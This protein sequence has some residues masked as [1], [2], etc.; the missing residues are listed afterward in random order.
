M[1]LSFLVCRQQ[2][3]MQSALKQQGASEKGHQDGECSSECKLCA[4]EN[5]IEDAADLKSLGCTG[6]ED[7]LQEG[8]PSA[9]Q[10]LLDAG[11]KVWMLTGDTVSTAVNIAM[12][13]NL[14]D[15]DMENDKRLFVFDKDMD[16]S[17]KIRQAIDDANKQIQ[18]AKTKQTKHKHH[19]SDGAVD[20]PLFGLAMHGD[21]WKKMQRS[22]KRKKDADDK[23]EGKEGGKEG[24]EGEEKAK[25]SPDLFRQKMGQRKKSKRN[26]LEGQEEESDDKEKPKKEEESDKKK[27]AEGE[28]ETEGGKKKSKKADKGDDKDSNKDKDDSSASPSSASS[29][30]DSTLLDHF[31]TLCSSCQ[32][33]IACR[34]EPKEKADI[35]DQMRDRTKR[36]CLAI[37]DGQPLTQQPHNT[38]TAHRY[39]S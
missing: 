22:R 32:S 11:M 12:A 39:K 34:L 4:V 37:G 26:L 6:I 17:G 7:K 13:C 19:S 38:H 23:E 35:V 21:V 29:S 8:V 15:S 1:P 18:Q 30:S 10:Q 3:K 9:L 33:V 24:K 14:I 36:T 25:T 2:D 28:K 27:K 20:G 5:E 16:S 31:F